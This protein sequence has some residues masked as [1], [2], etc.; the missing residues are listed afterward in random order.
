MTTGN[1]YRYWCAS[2]LVTLSEGGLVDGN[3]G[4]SFSGLRRAQASKWG[5]TR[6]RYLLRPSRVNCVF[7][8]PGNLSVQAPCARWGHQVKADYVV[9]P[10]DA[11]P[12]PGDA[13]LLSW[14]TRGGG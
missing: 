6:L 13:S 10:K 3:V 11:T 2:V 12:G 14:R 5:V 9:R 1:G 8:V 7:I 4:D